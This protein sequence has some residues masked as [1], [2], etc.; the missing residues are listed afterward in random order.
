MGYIDINECASD[1]TNECN[2]NCSNTPAGSYTCYCITGY[3]LDSDD[4]TCVGKL[5]LN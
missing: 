5:F 2:Q 4:T 3:E 1:S